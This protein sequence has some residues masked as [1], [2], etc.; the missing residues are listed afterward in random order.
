[1]FRGRNGSGVGYSSFDD[2]GDGQDL[3]ADLKAKLEDYVT[4][5]QADKILGCKSCDNAIKQFESSFG[6]GPA[7]GDA[8]AAASANTF[9]KEEMGK[10]IRKY[11]GES[12]SP[13]NSSGPRK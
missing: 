4:P 3:K 10:E 11:F 6:E 13:S 5:K 7:S 8:E 1:M 2:S 12:P 9:I